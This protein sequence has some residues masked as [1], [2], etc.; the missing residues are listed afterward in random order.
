[1]TTEGSIVFFDGLCALCNRWV[2]RMLQRDERGVLAFAPLQG[3]TARRLLDLPS[4]RDPESLVLLDEGRLHTRSDGVLRAL[5]LLGGRWR[6][7][8]RALALVPRALRDRVYDTV[9][10]N[11]YRWFGRRDTCRLPE[12]DR[13]RRRFLP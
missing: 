3:E 12:D 2:D 5:H 1:M 7:L 8:S 13:E 4:G 10:R 9:A 6:L 11:R